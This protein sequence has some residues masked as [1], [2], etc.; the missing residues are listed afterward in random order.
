[1][2]GAGGATDWGLLNRAMPF[3]HRNLPRAAVTIVVAGTARFEEGGR[4]AHL[5]SGE[6]VV[7]DVLRCGTEAYAGD[8]QVALAIEWD[9]S[10]HGA[11]HTRPFVVDRLC[12]VD[13][14]RLA[15]ATTNLSGPDPASAMSEIFTILRAHGFAFENVRASDLREKPEPEL[16]RLQDV[17]SDR[18]SRLEEFPTIEDVSIAL[19]WNQRHIHRRMSRLREHYHVLWSHWRELVHAARMARALRLLSAGGATELVA[20]SCGFR[21][22]SALC[23]AFAK[24]GLPSPGRLAQLARADVLAR[25]GELIPA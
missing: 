8:P 21:S 13:R 24:S 1:M 23:H 3:V 25:W 19:D 2:S 12:P 20:R 6:F 5:R 14:A 10:A 7:S 15:R 22:A 16:Q 4:A 18:L 9:P 17:V 11:M